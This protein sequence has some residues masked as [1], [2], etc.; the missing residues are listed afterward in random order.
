MLIKSKVV[1]VLLGGI[2]ASTLSFVAYAGATEDVVVCNG[3][4]KTVVESRLPSCNGGYEIIADYTNRELYEGCWRP[5]YQDPT[6][7]PDQHQY[8]TKIYSWATPTATESEQ[9]RLY[10]DLYHGYGSKILAEGGIVVK[11]GELRAKVDL[12][13]NGYMNAYDLGISSANR[14]YFWDWVNEN[15]VLTTKNIILPIADPTLSADLVHLFNSITSSVVSLHI[16]LVLTFQF[17]D[18]S[19]VKG[20]VNKYGLFVQVPNSRIDSHGNV[21]PDSINGFTHNGKAQVYNFTGDG[22]PYDEDDFTSLLTLNG[23]GLAD[24]YSATVTV[25]KIVCVPYN[26]SD[27]PKTICYTASSKK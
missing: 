1:S 3:C 10:A 25:G 13:D 21:L 2:L 4:S 9:F 12:G 24:S 15:H 17:R 18:G 7:R 11:V 5:M 8:P 6:I 22:S 23:I 27:K 16:N 19:T 20:K 14:T 26:E